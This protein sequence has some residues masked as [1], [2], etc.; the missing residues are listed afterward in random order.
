MRRGVRKGAAAS[1]LITVP[2]TDIVTIFLTYGL[3]GPVLA[4]FRPVAALVTGIGAGLVINLFD[5][6]G[7]AGT[8]DTTAV[9]PDAESLDP[10]GCA[11]GCA[12]GCGDAGGNVGR[13]TRGAPRPRGW[14]GAALRYGF[15]EFFDDLLLRL[16]LGH[17]DRR[18][19]HRVD[20]PGSA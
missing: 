12:D 4:V 19:D 14:L 18:R 17:R 2:E 3:T 11:N 10:K 8:A 1:F 13:R 5:R 6:R 20:P 7:R 9:R 15:V 16:L